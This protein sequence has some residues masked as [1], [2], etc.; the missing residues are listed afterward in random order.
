MAPVKLNLAACADDSFNKKAVIEFLTLEGVGPKEI[1][2][3]LRNVYKESALSY[4]SVRRWVVHFKSDSS[5]IIGKPC[6]GRPLTAVT[7]G[8]KRHVDEM[9]RGDRQVTVKD[10]ADEIAIGHKAVQEIINELGYSKVC[11]PLG[12]SYAD[13]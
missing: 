6:S 13:G 4:A 9:I 1:S 10:I 8:N 12:S 5:D 3:R 7:S 11:A 2:E